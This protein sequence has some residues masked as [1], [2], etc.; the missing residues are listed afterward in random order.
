MGG[1]S[2]WYD[3]RIPF[4]REDAGDI[5]AIQSQEATVIATLIR[6]GFTAES[7]VLAVKNNDWTLLKHSGL[8]SVQLQPPGTEPPPAG[9]P[10]LVP[11][12]ANGN[13]N[14]AHP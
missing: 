9:L 5:A 6:E 13:G 3:A 10:A 2:L 14:G 1:A 4:M 11:A 8:M 7:V 12:G